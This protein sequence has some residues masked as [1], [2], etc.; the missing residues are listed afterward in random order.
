MIEATK[1]RMWAMYLSLPPLDISALLDSVILRSEFSYQ[2]LLEISPVG[3]RALVHRMILGVSVLP[4][5]GSLAL[6]P[7]QSRPLG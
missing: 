4:A 5:V 3:S 2:H 1:S 6:L 7:V